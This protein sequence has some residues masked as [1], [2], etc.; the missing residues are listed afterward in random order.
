MLAG[1]ARQITLALLLAACGEQK[2]D[3]GTPCPDAD[4]DG[5]T[6]ADDDCD[7]EDAAINPGATEGG[8]LYTRG[9]T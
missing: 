4:A 8:L 2:D 6:L 1:F 5:Y 9:R 3:T 7:D